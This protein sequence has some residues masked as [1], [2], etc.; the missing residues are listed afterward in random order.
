MNDSRQ[1]QAVVI[2]SF[3]KKNDDIRAVYCT[4]TARME[5]TIWKSARQKT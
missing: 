5:L 2:F 3:R 4:K 1:D